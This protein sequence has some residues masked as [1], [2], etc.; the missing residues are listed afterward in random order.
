ME[1]DVPR[2]GLYEDNRKHGVGNGRAA[3]RFEHEYSVCACYIDKASVEADKAIAQFRPI[4]DESVGILS[5]VPLWLVP[6]D[7]KVVSG[8][9]VLKIGI[10]GY[11]DPF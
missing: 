10:V 3:L 4:A 9:I 8:N 5:Y 2:T 6:S 11:F 1:L 7:I